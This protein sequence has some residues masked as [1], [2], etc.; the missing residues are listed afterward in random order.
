MLKVLGGGLGFEL[1]SYDW[2]Q[3]GSVVNIHRPRAHHA[4]WVLPPVC[5]N[6]NDMLCKLLHAIAAENMR[7]CD[8]RFELE[9]LTKALSRLATSR[10]AHLLASFTA[11]VSAIGVQ[12]AGSYLLVERFRWSV[13]ASRPPHHAV[14]ILKVSAP[15][16][17]LLA[18]LKTS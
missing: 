14:D 13:L 2:T 5:C 15:L 17:N 3:T 9:S 1:V 11:D 7:A 10:I 18:S 6:W 12:N 16:V 4:A 8:V